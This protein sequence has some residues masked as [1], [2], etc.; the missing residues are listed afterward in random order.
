MKVIILAKK[1][2][3]NDIDKIETQGTEDRSTL[4]TKGTEDRLNSFLL[5]NFLFFKKNILL[6]EFCKL[7]C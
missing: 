5:I 7:C 3:W 6:I 2:V 4:E 1:I